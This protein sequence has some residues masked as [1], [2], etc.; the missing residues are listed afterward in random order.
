MIE[1]FRDVAGKHRFRIR[2]KNGEIIAQSEAYETAANARKGVAA[3]H[4]VHQDSR[5]FRN[6][7]AAAFDAGA[8]AAATGSATPP[9]NP[10]KD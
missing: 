1:Y 10:W 2:A 9:R 6:L 5:A 8:N 3:L 7:L 4:R